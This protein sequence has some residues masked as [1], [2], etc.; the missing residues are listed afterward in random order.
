MSSN[1]LDSILVSDFRARYIS[2]CHDYTITPN[3]L[4][5]KAISNFE[6]DNKI[7]HSKS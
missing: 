3:K 1:I 7:H 6:A 5:L 2:K 4:I